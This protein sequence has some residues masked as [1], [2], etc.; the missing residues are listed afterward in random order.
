MMEAAATNCGRTNQVKITSLSSG[1]GS[2]SGS[3][4]SSSSSF[5]YANDKVSTGIFHACA[6]LDNGDLKCW[7]G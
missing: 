7:G 5:A 6:I 4:S 1:S 3:G 2:G